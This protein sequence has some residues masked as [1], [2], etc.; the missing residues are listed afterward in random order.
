[1]VHSTA[2]FHWAINLYLPLDPYL[3]SNKTL[4]NF[5]GIVLPSKAAQTSETETFAEVQFV[6]DSCRFISQSN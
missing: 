6:I 5:E 4:A 1:M 3:K 2:R